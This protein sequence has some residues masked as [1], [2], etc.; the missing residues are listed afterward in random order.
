MISNNHSLQC[1]RTQKIA[2]LNRCTDR[3]AWT[4]KWSDI[5]VGELSYLTEYVSRLLLVLIRS[6]KGCFLIF[7]YTEFDPAGYDGK[8]YIHTYSG[9]M[10]LNLKVPK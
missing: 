3:Q 6:Q 5:F 4:V 7:V 1:S 2:S 9:G 10:I 8:L